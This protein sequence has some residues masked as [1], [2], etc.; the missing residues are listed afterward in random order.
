MNCRSATCPEWRL[1]PRGAHK[2]ICWTIWL[3]VA[4]LYASAGCAGQQPFLCASDIDCG[5]PSSCDHGTCRTAANAPR[6]D[7][8]TERRVLYPVGDATVTSARC[9]SDEALGDQDLLAVG[10]DSNGSVYRSYLL[11]DLSP[12]EGADVTRAELR[13]FA[14]PRWSS[15]DEVL[16]LFLFPVARSWNQDAMTWRRQ[17]GGNGGP[18][19]TTLLR[20]EHNRE[21]AFDVTRLVSAW[22]SASLP[23]RGVLLATGG[24]HS[25]SRVVFFSSEATVADHRPVI[26]VEVR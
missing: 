25:S 16:S 1:P 12:L 18:M 6:P 23:N 13:L 21:V 9:C 19:A 10:R 17:P 15:G 20:P 26:E 3:V 8:R 22:A 7:L 11:F 2:T 4:V 14:H 24:D 5:A